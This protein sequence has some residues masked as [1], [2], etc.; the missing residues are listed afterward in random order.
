M[1]YLKL[2]T[3]LLL[4]G[5]FTLSAQ[6]DIQALKAYLAQA[7][8]DWNIPGMAVGIV[9]DGTVVLSEGFGNLEAG[10][11]EKAD[12]NSL[13]AIASNTKA[14]IS[15]AIAIL[16]EQ[17]QLN[18]DDP[19]KKHL[20]YFELYDAYTT[21]HT[22]VRDLLCHRA[23][24]GTFSGDVIWYKSNYTAEETVKRIKEVPQAYEFR[25][26]Y[27]YSNLMFITAGEVIKAISGKPWDEF[28][29][30]KIFKP[31]D[32]SRTQTSV[33]PL[34]KMANVAMPHKPD[35][36]KN[37]PIPYVNWDNMG[38]AGGII[39]STNDM[40]Q[41]I[42]LQID[43]GQHAGKVIFSERSQSEFWHPHN[44]HKVSKRSNE[45]YRNRHFSAYGLGW[46][47]SDYA[48]RKLVS[49]G[50]GYDGM[51]S[52]VVIVPEE[53]LGMVILT[54]SMKGISTPLT[55]Y[56]M[57]TFFGLE[58]KDWSQTSLEQS[59]SGARRR[60]SQIES[61]TGSRILGTSPDLE[62]KDYAGLYRCDMYGDLEV[63]LID[64]GLDLNFI[65][66]PSLNA[67]LRHWHLNTFKINWN[68][69]HAWF[70]FGTVQ[71]ILD[72]NASIQ[73]IQFDVPNDDIFFEE[74]KAKRV[75]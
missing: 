8:K 3:F 9:K 24:L 39:S 29:K 18:W 5:T 31:L 70:D 57:D 11:S 43:G 21:E 42:Q 37:N 75:E 54:N 1:N 12:G 13:F 19:V 45:T 48:G 16:V 33:E 6:T 44:N 58:P 38:A 73:E 34:K 14:F 55:Y 7:Q 52:R 53:K 67:K 40:L 56:I 2:L 66:A 65:S 46:G 17:G 61:R 64:G 15:A 60:Q 28:I 26:G 35:G 22:T 23:G 36:E 50:G 47:I 30:E 69:T 10:K 4:C 74:I 62:L 59:E 27:G 32:M 68:E 63:K 20:P 25:S 71:F 51:Y 72:N 41:W 49:H